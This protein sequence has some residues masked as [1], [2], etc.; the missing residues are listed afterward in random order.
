MS[1]YD[2]LI[3]DNFEDELWNPNIT[4]LQLR[5]RQVDIAEL[6]SEAETEAEEMIQCLNSQKL[7]AI[8]SFP[9][10]IVGLALTG[11]SVFVYT[12]PY[13]L[14]T[15]VGYLLA[16]LSIFEFLFL[17][18][19]MQAFSL[20]YI[21]TL[22]CE[23]IDKYP[24]F[25][26]YSELYIYPLTHVTKYMCVCISI[27]ISIQQWVSV[28]LPAKVKII[29]TMKRT[30]RLLI[31]S[32]IFSVFLSIPRFLERKMN[33]HN[34]WPSENNTYKD[35]PILQAINFFD[36]NIFNAFIIFF[37][38]LMINLSIIALL[39]WAEYGRMKMTTQTVKDRKTSIMLLAVL[40]AYVLTHSPSMI[41][42]YF[43]K[44]LVNGLHKD[45]SILR[46]EISNFFMCC[47]PLFSFA[48]YLIFSEKYRNTVKSM[49]TGNSRRNSSNNP[50]PV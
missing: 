39:K 2:T 6:S 36:D 9:L 14:K 46:K 29:C 22:N 42:E 15:T 31:F 11:I 45:I 17:L 12:R 13:Q 3:H 34:N 16:F 49:F 40:L 18:F 37:V 24:K 5:H 1:F 30:K 7:L 4:A 44:T 27:M 38:L 33:P 43:D 19:S 8:A 47:H 50:V 32:F 41:I 20:S 48:D 21:P 28:F 25:K 35:N 23:R 26:A 10:F